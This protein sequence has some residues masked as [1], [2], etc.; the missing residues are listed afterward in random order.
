MHT[1]RRTW[2]SVFQKALHRVSDAEFHICLPHRNGKYARYKYIIGCMHTLC[3][4]FMLLTFE[5]PY[6]LKKT[7]VFAIGR[8]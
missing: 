4:V 5:D 2:A 8:C 6:R 7:L 3:I 1:G